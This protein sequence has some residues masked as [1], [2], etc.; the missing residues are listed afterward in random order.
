MYIKINVGLINRYDLFIKNHYFVIN[1]HHHTNLIL[2]D[3]LIT[4]NF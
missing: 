2:L 4:Q 3:F 1:N